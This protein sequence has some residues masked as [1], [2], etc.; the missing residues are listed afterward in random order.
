MQWFA[1]QPELTLLAVAPMFHVTGMQGGM[2]GPLYIGNT[3]VLLPRWDRDVAA[4]CVQRYKVT[5][6]TA[7]PTM[8]QD[9]FV[10]PNIDKYDLSL[11]PALERRRRRHAG[12]GRAAACWTS[13]SPTVEGYG[14]TETI[15]GHAHQSAGSR[16]EAVPGHPDLSTSI[17][18]SSIPATLARIAARRGRRDHH[19]RPAGVPGLLEQARGHARRP[20]SSID[21]KRFFRTGDLGRMDEDGYFFMVDRLKRMINASGYKVWPTEVESLMY[22]HPGRPGGLRHRRQG[23]AS[24]RD[25]QGGHRAARRV[26]R[27]HRGAGHHRLVPG[28]HGGLQGAANR[29]SSSMRCRNPVPARSCGASCRNAKADA[30]SNQLAT[31]S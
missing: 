7:I 27:P 24:R 9:F 3:M 28:E 29:S 4:Q 12:G 8:I 18:A 14:L 25:G 6:W 21:G 1:L 19:A 16:Q 10:N 13:A 2:N 31:S 5:S 20:S 11:D 22:Q 30:D 15:G 26:A 17:R 23:R